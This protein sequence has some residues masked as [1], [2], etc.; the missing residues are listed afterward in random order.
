MK[1]I[2]LLHKKQTG[3]KSRAIYAACLIPSLFMAMLALGKLPLAYRDSVGKPALF[4]VFAAF[5]LGFIW[6]YRKTDVKCPLCGKSIR[7]NPFAALA[8]TTGKCGHCGKQIID[9]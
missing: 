6:V 7:D 9:D 5:G 2:D 1:R 8:D 4:M 3:A